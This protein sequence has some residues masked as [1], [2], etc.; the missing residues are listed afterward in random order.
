[1]TRVC[2]PSDFLEI[3]VIWDDKSLYG[4][5]LSGRLQDTVR[6]R[7]YPVTAD[8]LTGQMSRPPTERKAFG[9]RELADI[10][11]R[12]RR[13]PAHRAIVENA[14]FWHPDPAQIRP[15]SAIVR[16]TCSAAALEVPLTVDA[17]SSLR[18]AML[19]GETDNVGLLRLLDDT[20]QAISQAGFARA[21]LNA[22]RFPVTPVFVG[23]ACVTWTD[24]SLRLWSDP[25]LRPKNLRYPLHYQPISPCDVP[26]SRHAIL[27]T[28]SHSDHFAPGSLLMFAADTPIIIPKLA[29]ESLLSLDL[30]YRLKQLGFIDIRPLGWGDSVQLGAFDVT[31]VPFYGEQPLGGGA[32]PDRPERMVGNGYKVASAEGP[33]T[34]ILADSGSDPWAD[35]R[36]GARRIRDVCGEVDILFAN[37][38]RWRVYPPQYL[39]TSVP[40]FLCHVPDAELAVPQQIM[41]SPEDLCAVAEILG[42]SFVV[43]YAMGGV[44]WFEEIGLGSDNLKPRYGSAFEGGALDLGHF[45][46]PDTLVAPAFVFVNALPG[47]GIDS[48]GALALPD[49][50]SLPTPLEFSRADDAASKPPRTLAVGSPNLPQELVGDLFELARLDPEAWFVAMPGFCELVAGGGEASSFLWSTVDRLSFE[51]VWRLVADG[52]LCAGLFRA[53]PDW[54]TAFENL[55]RRL[56]LALRDAERPIEDLRSVVRDISESEAP[57]SVVESICKELLGIKLDAKLLARPRLQPNPK[58]VFSEVLSEPMLPAHADALVRL[59]GKS[60]VARSLILVKALH[61]VFI[62]AQAVGRDVLPADEAAFFA[63]VLA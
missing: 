59:S 28:H 6:R 53:S 29:R 57:T 46:D 14:V 52:P 24:G 42:A 36:E 54:C 4:A 15:I 8:M 62:T 27:I 55:N 39:T 10:V 40:E 17:I 38:R 19:T 33:S 61:N 37:H 1:M 47:Q 35:A 32:R 3:S 2:A 7:L 26:E 21:Q 12:E 25:F 31:A 56:Y 20:R 48:K 11:R 23:H 49:H 18:H 58:S 50:M 41:Y 63:R 16:A 45:A 30:A 43:P 13:S 9:A 5:S 22:D 44:A 34:V 51:G 60:A